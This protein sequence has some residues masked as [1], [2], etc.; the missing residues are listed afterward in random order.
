[1][2]KAK[3]KSNNMKLAG[4][5]V[6]LVFGLI[7][8]SLVFKIIFLIKDSKF[9]SS[10]KFNVAFIGKETTEV[11][12]FSPNN[13]SISILE[14]ETRVESKDLT[15]ILQVPIDG[16]I[17]NSAKS[18]DKNN[19]FSSLFKSFIPFGE[20]KEKMT[21]IDSFRLF[22]FSRGVSSNST[23]TR[24]L[25]KGLNE[26]QKSTIV[27]LSFT[28]PKI[29]EES[30]SIEIINATGI[31]GLGGRLATFISNVGGNVVLITSDDNLDNRSKI[32]YSGEETYTIKKLSSIL[33]FPL[34]KAGKRG[35]ADVIIIIG[36]EKDNNY[37]F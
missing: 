25:T 19:L 14:L 37:N 20:K 12:S 23:Y 16:V 21:S 35:I 18:I 9:D 1:M 10:N 15:K 5:F 13:K 28:D 32:V 33:G 7:F 26:N 24:E 8:L 4:L 27:S 31:F 29:Y 22:L 2:P 36:K 17:Y 34:E 30:L 6:L 3:E 11:V